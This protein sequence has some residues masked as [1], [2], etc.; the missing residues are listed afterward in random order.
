MRTSNQMR[1]DDEMRESFTVKK[2]IFEHNLKWHKYVS[3]GHAL[4][5]FGIA[6]WSCCAVQLFIIA[7]PILHSIFFTFLA[8]FLIHSFTA[9]SLFFYPTFLQL[10]FINTSTKASQLFSWSSSLNISPPLSVSTLPKL[11]FSLFVFGVILFFVILIL[12]VPI[13]RRRSLALSAPLL[14]RTSSRMGSY[15]V[16]YILQSEDYKT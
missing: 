1:W 15:I 10:I 14:F 13:S 12:M 5:I 7:L 4:F 3:P 6:L 8:L 11:Y 16:F 2:V 9:S